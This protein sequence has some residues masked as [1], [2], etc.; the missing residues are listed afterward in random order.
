M[1]GIK[2][3]YEGAAELG[4]CPIEQETWDYLD[5][6]EESDP[7]IDWIAYCEYDYEGHDGLHVCDCIRVESARRLIDMGLETVEIAN[8][9]EYFCGGIDCG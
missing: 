3:F 6:L 4:M 1:S 5:N 7:S 9:V 2:R 8:F